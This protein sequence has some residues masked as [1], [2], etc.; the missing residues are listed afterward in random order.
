M[1]PHQHSIL[2]FNDAEFSLRGA[3]GPEAADKAFIDILSS[4]DGTMKVPIARSHCSG[5]INYIRFSNKGHFDPCRN[6]YVV[7]GHHHHHNAPWSFFAY[8][9][10]IQRPSLEKG[11]KMTEKKKEKKGRTLRGHSLWHPS[12]RTT[13]KSRRHALA[14]IF[15]AFC[16]LRNGWQAQMVFILA[17][18]ASSSLSS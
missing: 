16:G 15:S 1:I 2:V 8:S 3:M 18:R 14:S 10:G 6:S 13:P 9:E 5:I 17:C 12:E 11:S 7:H 4:E